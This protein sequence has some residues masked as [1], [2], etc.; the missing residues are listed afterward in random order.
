MVAIVVVVWE[1]SD[2]ERA[3]TLFGETTHQILKLNY[4]QH[5]KIFPWV[6]IDKSNMKVVK[7]FSS[8]EDVIPLLFKKSGDLKDLNNFIVIKDESAVIS[9]G[10]LSL[11]CCNTFLEKYGKIRYYLQTYEY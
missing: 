4:N 10:C 8:V 5:M 1:S 6:V 7:H 9:F 11:F 3:M 2:V